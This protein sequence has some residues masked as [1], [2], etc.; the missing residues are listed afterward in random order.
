M[1]RAFIRFS[2]LMLIMFIDGIITIFF[3]KNEIVQY[4]FYAKAITKTPSEQQKILVNYLKQCHKQTFKEEK[5][6]K[7]RTKKEI[8]T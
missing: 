3:E 5:N 2:I 7:K 1:I 6:D 4:T 8:D